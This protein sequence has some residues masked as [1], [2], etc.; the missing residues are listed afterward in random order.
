MFIL[1][2][3]TLCTLIHFRFLF[4]FHNYY[5]SVQKIRSKKSITFDYCTGLWMFLEKLNKFTFTSVLA[6]R[7]V[8]LRPTRIV[9]SPVINRHCKFEITTARYLKLRPTSV[10]IRYPVSCVYFFCVTNLCPLSCILYLI[11]LSLS[12][13][14][15]FCRVSLSCRHWSLIFTTGNRFYCEG[16]RKNP[17]QQMVINVAE[18]IKSTVKRNIC[19]SFV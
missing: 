8:E 1:F 4:L 3:S 17:L 13:I 11:L 18:P 10:W 12:C 16:D 5:Y 2:L 14:R 7:Y 6:T 19:R 9:T 15:F